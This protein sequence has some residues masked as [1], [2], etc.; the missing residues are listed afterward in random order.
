M[1]NN[2]RKNKINCK[3]IITKKNKPLIKL[4][5][6]I[7]AVAVIVVQV[8]V[9]VIWMI[10]KVIV[11]QHSPILNSKSQRLQLSQLT[12]KLIYKNRININSSSSSRKIHKIILKKLI[13]S[14]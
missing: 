13:N 9:K 10:Y 5:E 11:L 3:L 12:K 8:E 14:K 2:I 6:E 7:L 1:I 4:I